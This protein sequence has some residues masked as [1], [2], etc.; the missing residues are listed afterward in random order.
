LAPP[1]AAAAAII[2]EALIA[3][4]FLRSSSDR[5]SHRI[6]SDLTAI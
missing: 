5:E 1:R 4:R 6:D 3:R 2:R